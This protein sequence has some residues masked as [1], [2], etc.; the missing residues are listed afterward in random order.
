[1]TDYQAQQLVALADRLGTTAE[2]LW[3]VLVVQARIEV[4]VDLFYVVVLVALFF[5]MRRLHRVLR[6]KADGPGFDAELWNV[7]MVIGWVALAGLAI[8]GVVE[9]A[10]VPGLLLNPEY[11]ALKQLLATVKK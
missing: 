3:H 11:W 8:I 2:H 7:P 6:K 9:L 10:Q 1:M 4:F 5:L